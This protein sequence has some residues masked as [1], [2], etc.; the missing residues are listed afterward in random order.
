MVKCW[1]ACLARVPYLGHSS[2]AGKEK[3]GWED[4]FFLK[5]L[6][7]IHCIV[8]RNDVNIHTC[9]KVPDAGLTPEAAT[10]LV[11]PRAYVWGLSKCMPFFIGRQSLG[12]VKSLWYL[13]MEPMNPGDKAA[14]FL[15]F[16][17]KLNIS[18]VACKKKSQALCYSAKLITESAIE[19]WMF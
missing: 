16:F 14:M 17:V 9:Q 1:S 4:L 12:H 5:E 8:T 11:M 3:S 6:I 13:E 2:Q 10:P 15:Q 18:P 7:I 19:V